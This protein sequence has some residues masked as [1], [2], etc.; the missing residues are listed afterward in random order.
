L[1]HPPNQLSHE[2]DL[3][4]ARQQSFNLLYR[5]LF[6][7]FAEDRK[8]L[9]F[10]VNIAY[11][12]NRSLGRARDEIGAT[13]DRINARR[14]V[15]YPAGQVTLWNDLTNLFDLIDRGHATYGV[16]AYNGGLFD[17]EQHPFLAQK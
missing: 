12:A 8:L 2:K 1:N 11:T 13:L 3:E 4:M 16:P 10:G 15:D 7:L 6:V 17:A 9:P 5:V 14:D